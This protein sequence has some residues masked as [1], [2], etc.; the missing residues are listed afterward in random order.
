M[1][2]LTSIAPIITE[3]PTMPINVIGLMLLFGCVI[4]SELETFSDSKFQHRMGLNNSANNSL[5][6]KNINR[7]NSFE[8]CNAREHD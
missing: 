4:F 6:T 1:K 3:M 8:N 2:A 7:E 5:R